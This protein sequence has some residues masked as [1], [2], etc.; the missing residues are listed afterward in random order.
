[1]TSNTPITKTPTN[2]EHTDTHLVTR[3]T[4]QDNLLAA[5]VMSVSTALD[6]DDIAALIQYGDTK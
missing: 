1:M 3:A 2:P 4:G 6:E 5:L